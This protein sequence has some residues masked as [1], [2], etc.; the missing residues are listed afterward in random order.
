MRKY[1]RHFILDNYRNDDIQIKYFFARIRL[2]GNNVV[3]NWWFSYFYYST[4]VCPSLVK[5]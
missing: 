3:L 1:R 5:M 4:S 2:M